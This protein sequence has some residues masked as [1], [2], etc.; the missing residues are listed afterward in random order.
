MA[1]LYLGAK[2]VTIA[3][4]EAISLRVGLD[5]PL[6]TMMGELP[7]KGTTSAKK[8][9]DFLPNLDDQAYH[10]KNE[11][12]TTVLNLLEKGRTKSSAYDIKHSPLATFFVKTMGFDEINHQ[13]SHAKEFFK[14]L[15]SAGDLP[16]KISA[17]KVFITGFNSTV[18]DEVTDGILKVFDSRRE[19]LSRS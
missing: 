1:R 6:S 13:L 14:Q 18:T 17:A 3:F 5:I 15:D 9:E 19:A 12:E 8:L 4:I 2:L 16:A 11:L 7:E 10:P